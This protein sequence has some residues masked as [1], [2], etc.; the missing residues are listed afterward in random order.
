M[1]TVGSILKDA[2]EE[3]GLTLAQ[4]EKA[5]KI[6][7]KFLESIE[8]D[9]YSTLPS[10]S[11]A[12]GFIKNYSDF[13]GVSSSKSLAF[14][15]RQTEE[16]TRTSLLPKGMDESLKVSWLRLTPGRFLAILLLSLVSVFVVYLG[17]QYQKLQSAPALSVQAPKDALT[18][19]ERRVDVLGKT[20]TDATVIVNGVS[21]LVRGDGKFFDQITLEPGDNAIIITA[22]SRYGKATTV[23]RAVRF[24]VQNP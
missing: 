6:R 11:Y 24:D 7:E 17:F 5:T 15:R 21:V 10:L 16:V 23:S 1:K 13:L 12:K 9:D 18:T 14:F 20:D 3:K 2:R 4:V 19:T 8:R 22:T